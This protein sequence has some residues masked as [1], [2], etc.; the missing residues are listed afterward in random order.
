MTFKMGRPR[1]DRSFCEKHQQQRYGYT[2]P[3][4]RHTWVCSRC[5]V[6]NSLAWRSRNMQR[7]RETHRIRMNRRNAE[8]RVVRAAQRIKKGL[9]VNCGKHPKVLAKRPKSKTRRAA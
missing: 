3:S 7:Y 6:E 5:N 4:G 2:A 1:L 8:K 9:C